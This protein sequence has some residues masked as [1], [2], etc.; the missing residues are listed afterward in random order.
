MT[1]DDVERLIA[2]DR[3]SPPQPPDGAAAAGW[4]RLQHDL[5]IAAVPAFDVPPPVV[6]A[7][8]VAKGGASLGVIGKI[9]ATV[10]IVGGTTTAVVVTR[11]EPAPVIERASSIERAVVEQEDAARRAD[12]DQTAPEPAPVVI[13][14]PPVLD[15]P[16]EPAAIDLSPTL[17]DTLRPEPTRVRKPKAARTE[18]ND[19]SPSSSIEQEAA[20]VSSAQ[21]ALAQ[22]RPTRALD[23]LDEHQRR[24]PHGAM[25][26]DRDA[27][28]VVALCRAGRP[29]EA[30]RRRAQ[31]FR[32]WPKSLHAARVRG[33][34]ES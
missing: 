26:E 2:Q 24:H 5:A 4:R 11:P 10:T 25:A 14:P 21:R 18:S 1:P 30:E 28:R 31:F 17:D 29:E 6:E 7:A 34:C 27:L 3:E 8:A 23:L 15:P 13:P 16:T 12:A 20:L 22:G 33:A 32:R 19:A 9:V